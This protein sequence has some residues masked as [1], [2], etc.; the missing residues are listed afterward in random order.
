MSIP[1]FDRAR[2]SGKRNALFP[3]TNSTTPL[4]PLTTT[5]VGL[6]ESTILPSLSIH[7]GLSLITYGIAR[8]TNRVDLKDGLWPAGQLINVWWSA[9]GR[10]VVYQGVSVSKAFSTLGWNE[11]VLLTGLTLWGGRLFYRIATRAY[12][13]GEDDARYHTVK[14][15]KDFWNKAFFTVFLPEAVIQTLITLPFTIPFRALPTD[16]FHVPHEYIDFIHG[17]AVGL[18]SAGFSLEVA[19]DATLDSHR[20]KSSDLN[21]EGIWSIVRH[22]NYLG[23]ALVHASFPILLYA[24]GV[25]HPLSLVG[26][27]ANYVF[28]RYIGGDKE[29]EAHR[30]R[31]YS[32]SDPIKFSQLEEWRKEKNS[33]WP[34]L[35]EFANPWTWAVVGAGFAGVGLE[36]I[37]REL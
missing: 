7:S 8:A 6:L 34:Q 3:D 9:V 16:T 1:V 22:P 32:S 23:D 20:A 24:S 12:K 17:L 15:E 2:S 27:L 35:K 11:K 18:F 29:N 30:E 36:R 26:P 5:S 33:F 31:R 13:R 10:R 21:R 37:L 19:A 4:R 28:L 25:L 14:E